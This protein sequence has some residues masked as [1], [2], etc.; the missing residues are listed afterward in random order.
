MRGIGGGGGGGG[1][2]AS[3]F[4]RQR[5][6]GWPNRLARVFLYSALRPI[7]S[8]SL[9]LSLSLFLSLEKYL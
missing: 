5:V 6:T 4:T 8:P 2:G 7:P 3:R 9:S 1:R